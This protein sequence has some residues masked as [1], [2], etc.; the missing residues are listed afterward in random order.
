[1]DLIGLA[2]CDFNISPEETQEVMGDS[3]LIYK[4][5]KTMF[6]KIGMNENRIKRALDT[7]DDKINVLLQN[8]KSQFLSDSKKVNE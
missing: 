3:Y 7:V 8:A 5:L 1:M 4:L 6:Y 2:R